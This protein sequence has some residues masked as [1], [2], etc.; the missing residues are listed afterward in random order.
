MR[1][2]VVVFFIVCLVP[3]LS[4]PSGACMFESSSAPVFNGEL[5][6]EVVSAGC[7]SPGCS[8][9]FAWVSFEELDVRQA[10]SSLTC[11]SGALRGCASAKYMGPSVYALCNG[12]NMSR[13][14]RSAGLVSE[15]GWWTNSNRAGRF[16]QGVFASQEDVALTG[17]GFMVVQQKPWLCVCVV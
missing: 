10:S 11:V 1:V 4:S 13:S 9:T 2:S 16:S 5:N 7:V 6:S 8:R 17:T 15:S 14:F 3:A 12:V